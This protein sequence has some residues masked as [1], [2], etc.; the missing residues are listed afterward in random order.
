M[1]ARQNTVKGGDDDSQNEA[2]DHFL[3][4]LEAVMEERGWTRSK[5]AAELNLGRSAV[6]EWWTKK[7]V[8][9]GEALLRLPELLE[10]EPA[11]L[12]GGGKGEDGKA[13]WK[14]EPEEALG[15]LDDAPMFDEVRAIL[16]DRSIPAGMKVLL[17]DAA[18][19]SWLAAA[20]YRG[21]VGGETRARAVLQAEETGRVRTG[22][23]ERVE[24]N[25]Q[26]RRREFQNTKGYRFLSGLSEDDVA[27][28]E[29]FLRRRDEGRGGPP[30]DPEEE[31][32]G[33]PT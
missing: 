9:M 13:K 14:E 6:T 17:I 30:E 4:R 29:E 7:R 12:F 8:P 22:V 16:R 27:A 2:L 28:V 10:V 31:S 1:H 11:R 26:E 25:A 24:A 21:E 3:E 5:L 23:I 20:L 15:E 19:S 32:E 33:P 18:N